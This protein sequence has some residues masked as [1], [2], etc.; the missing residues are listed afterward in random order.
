MTKTECFAPLISIVITGCCTCTQ[1]QA[2][3]VH[4]STGMTVCVYAF[5][6][7]RQVQVLA[8]TVVLVLSRAR[9]VILTAVYQLTGYSDCLTGFCEP[10]SPPYRCHASLKNV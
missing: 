2:C 3:S 5:Y 6:M 4:M 8:S 10:L 9:A 7:E 1:L